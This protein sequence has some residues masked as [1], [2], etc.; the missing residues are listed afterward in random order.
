MVICSF[1]LLRSHS[2]VNVLEYAEKIEFQ[3]YTEAYNIYKG[4]G[5]GEV[6]FFS[7][8]LWNRRN[9]ADPIGS[10]TPFHDA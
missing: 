3:I 9:G 5:E 4:E 1:F 2:P 8:K 10:A 6:G 7:A